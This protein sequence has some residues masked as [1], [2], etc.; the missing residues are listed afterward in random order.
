M[1]GETGRGYKEG[2]DKEKVVQSFQTIYVM[3][4]KWGIIGNDDPIYELQNEIA[5]ILK[6]LRTWAC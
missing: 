2:K 5:E 3:H 6:C 4:H 1:N